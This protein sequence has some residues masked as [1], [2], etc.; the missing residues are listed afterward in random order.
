VS[1]RNLMMDDQLWGSRFVPKILLAFTLCWSLGLLG[2]GLSWLTQHHEGSP[3]LGHPQ[4]VEEF[5]QVQN[6]PAGLFSYSGSSSWARIRLLV[7]STIQSERPEFQLRY[8]QPSHYR[9]NSATAI[10]MLLAGQLTFVQSARPLQPQEYAQAQQQGLAL[11]QI[12]IAID[13]IAVVVNPQLRIS[14]LT[15]SQL[16]AIYTGQL[17]NW[18]QLG[19][20]DLEITPYS[21][22]AGDSGTAEFFSQEVLEQQPFG[23]NVKTIATTTLA[24]QQTAKTPGGIYYAATPEVISQCSIKAVPLADESGE[25]IPPYQEPFVPAADCPQQRN[26]SNIQAFKMGRY[27]LMRY[28]YVVIK[29]NDTH[30]ERAGDAYASFLLTAQGQALIAKSGFVRIH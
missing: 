28:L 21:L 6:V 20:A 13:G 5:A 12:P 8:A 3:L 10:Q 18:K 4:Q 19:G 25:F 23:S 7:D 16:R 27:P 30:E 22:P 1:K 2:K 24:L 26:R 15:L 14:G 11:K 9:A 17:V 29:A